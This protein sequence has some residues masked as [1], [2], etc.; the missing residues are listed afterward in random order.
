MDRFRVWNETKS[1][2]FWKADGVSVESNT[3]PIKTTSRVYPVMELDR[4]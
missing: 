1:S 3:G 4:Q 2:G